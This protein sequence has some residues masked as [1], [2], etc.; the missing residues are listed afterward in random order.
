[1]TDEQ[2]AAVVSKTLESTPKNAT[3][4]STQS[5][6]KEKGFSQSSVSRI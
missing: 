5:M 6:A 2:V 3:H 1:V 4:W